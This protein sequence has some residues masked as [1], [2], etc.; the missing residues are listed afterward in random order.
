MAAPFPAP[1]DAAAPEPTPAVRL[2]GPGELA[3]VLPM[4][5]GFIPTE[6]LIV[7]ALHGPRSRIGL[8]MRIDLPNGEAPGWLVAEVL[9]RLAVEGADG[10]FLV[11]CTEAPD[12][13]EQLPRA[14]LVTALSEGCRRAGVRLA[15][16]LLLR[17]ARWR[18]YVCQN[19]SCCPAEGVPLDLPNGGPVSLVAA[20]HA[21]DGRAVLPSRSALR[22]SLAPAQ[23]PC[24]DTAAQALAAAGRARAAAVTAGGRAVTGQRDLLLW[25]RTMEQAEDCPHEADVETVAALVASL[26]DVLVRDEVLTWALEG[27]GSALLSLLLRLA[28]ACGPPSDAAVCTVL[29]WVAHTRGNG[30]MANIALD[31]ALATDPSYPMARL[32][33]QALDGQLPPARMRALLADSRILLHRQHPWTGWQS[34][35]ADT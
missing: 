2:R 28:R 19:R 33:R 10:A 6:S 4:L 3:A 18:S 30:A 14:A 24:A 25:R 15:D 23:G 32:S 12:A 13:A 16:A 5:C 22:A 21:L 7:V 8:T 17:C 1:F 11:V 26:D 35:P 31:R 29:A 27:D 9:E 34:R 20:E